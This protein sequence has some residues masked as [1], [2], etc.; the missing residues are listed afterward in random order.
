MSIDGFTPNIGRSSHGPIPAVIKEGFDPRSKTETILESTLKKM[1]KMHNEAFWD[2][3]ES[4]GTEKLVIA[5]ENGKT[6]TYEKGFFNRLLDAKPELA[7]LTQF[8]TIEFSDR[9]ELKETKAKLCMCGK[10]LTDLFGDIE[11][12]SIPLGEISQESFQEVLH[13]IENEVQD[14]STYSEGVQHAMNYLDFHRVGVPEGVHGKKDWNARGVDV[15]HVPPLPKALLEALNKP[16]PIAKNGSKMIDT[17]VILWMPPKLNGESITV[18]NLEKMAKSDAFGENIV[19]YQFI[20]EPIRGDADINEPLESG[21]WVALYKQPVAGGTSFA[22]QKKYIAV[23]CPGYEAPKARE[24]IAC[25]V[26]QYG[27]SG[28]KKERILGRENDVCYSRCEEQ[29]DGRQVV[30]GSLA[31]SGLIVGIKYAD[32][33]RVGVCSVRRF[34]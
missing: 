27:C 28:D 15:G 16:C 13:A 31:S 8:C 33:D 2:A 14:I 32:D 9:S 22:D 25:S 18:D 7:D 24:V 6:V 20:Y 5:C 4:K 34:F 26:M 12:E 23:N 3:L 21:Y 11:F 19:G 10:T 30:V 29:I 17:H 1:H